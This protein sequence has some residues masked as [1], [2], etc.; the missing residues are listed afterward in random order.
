MTIVMPTYNGD[1]AYLGE[2]FESA[3]RTGAP[4][5]V[6]DDC[7]TKPAVRALLDAWE[8]RGATIVRRARN[9]GLFGNLN[10]GLARV[11]TSH[12]VILCGDDR[13]REDALEI[14]ERH[15]DA[16]PDVDLV[17]NEF[18]SI[19]PQSRIVGRSHGAGLDA[20]S[21]ESRV[22]TH[23]EALRAVVQHGS[24]NGNIT[25]MLFRVAGF[26]RLPRFREG[27]RHAADWAYLVEVARHGKLALGRAPIADVR[28]H[29]ANLSGANHRSGRSVEEVAAV[30]GELSRDPQLSDELRDALYER[31]TYVIRMSWARPPALL[32][33]LRTL[34]R[35]RIGLVGSAKAVARMIVRENRRRWLP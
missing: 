14:M 31:A 7:S 15:I 5:L 11:T 35:E 10:D 6:V 25:G 24:F 32:S 22:L 33:A 8:A 30:I 34:R 21:T 20:I 12:A 16:W 3:I 17:V 4:V 1:A 29:D 27:W 2:A 13:L 26:L 28:W 9:L 19:D 18:V 23:D